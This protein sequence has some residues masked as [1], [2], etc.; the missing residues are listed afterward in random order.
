MRATV[1]VSEY[2]TYIPAAIILNR[3][4]ASH[5]G[6]PKWESTIALI[7]ILMQ[8]STILIDYA[9]FQYNTVMLGFVLASLASIVAGRH[10]WAC[11]FFVASLCFKQMALYYAPAVAAYL[12]GISLAP[13]LSLSR[14]MAIAAVTMLSFS[15]SFAPLILGSLYDA[16]RGISPTPGLKTPPLPHLISSLPISP[17]PD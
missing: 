1:L 17:S 7:A 2:L 5:R 13:R 10:L 15:V 11:V 8:P 14:F 16:H 3:A 9:H 6:V 4:L 12:M